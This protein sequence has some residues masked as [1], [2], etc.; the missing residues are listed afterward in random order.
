MLETCWCSDSAGDA[1]AI[2]LSSVDLPILTN[3]VKKYLLLLPDPVISSELYP[4]F[5]EAS[6]T[7]LT[8]C[9]LQH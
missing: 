3:I 7:Y 1:A 8:L 5:I 2:D 9:V 6:S 4:K